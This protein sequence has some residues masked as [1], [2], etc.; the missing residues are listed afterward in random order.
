[1]K[2]FLTGATGFV[3]SAVL[4]RLVADACDVTALIRNESVC[5]PDG[6]KKV[7]GE[8]ADF[9]SQLEILKQVQDDGVGVHGESALVQVAHNYTASHPDE[10]Q[11]LGVEILK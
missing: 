7:F 5:L 4:N 9:H 3:G 10:G 11:D 1:M 6:V 8:L 2:T